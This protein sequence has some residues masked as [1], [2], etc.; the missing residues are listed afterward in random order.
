M[1]VVKFVLWENRCRP[2]LKVVVRRCSLL[3]VALSPT[4]TLAQSEAEGTTI[5][6]AR[7]ELTLPDNCGS[8]AWF[9]ERIRTRSDRIRF[10][11][12]EQSMVVRAEVMRTAAGRIQAKMTLRQRDGTLAARSIEAADCEQ[13]LDG[14]ALVTAVTLDPTAMARQNPSDVTLGPKAS[15]PKPPE[16]KP[17]PTTIPETAGAAPPASKPLAPSRPRAWWDLSLGGTGVRGPAPGW[18]VGAEGSIRATWPSESPLSPSLRLSISFQQDRGF[19]ADG[20]IADFSLLGVAFDACPFTLTS[21]PVEMRS[22]GVGMVGMLRSSGRMTASP[23]I[24]YRPWYAAGASS[25]VDLL[26]G[27]HIA[28]PLRVFALFPALRDTYQ[29]SPSAFY[30]TPVVSFGLTASLSVRFR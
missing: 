27:D 7:L 16:A 28:L 3:A 10:H 13:A 29:F 22:C 24:H 17:A 26:L 25:T 4:L 6:S 2:N 9:L 15:T 23:E 12:D 14:L 19:K 11:P 18:M 5:V 20:G 30:R 21:G 1:G 8:P